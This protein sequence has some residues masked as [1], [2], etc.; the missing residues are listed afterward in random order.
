VSIVLYGG[1]GDFSLDE[2]S[3]RDHLAF[4]KRNVTDLLRVRGHQLASQYFAQIPWVLRDAN[5]WFNDEFSVLHATVSVDQYERVRSVSQSPEHQLAFRHIAETISE[6]GPYV[7]FIAVALDPNRKAAPPDERSL[8]DREIHKLVYKYIGVSGGYLGDFTYRSHHDFYADLELD[9]D[10]NKLPG[11]T[12]E[13]FIQIL[14][15]AP[16]DAQAKIVQG[17]L[18]R[19]PVDSSPIRSGAL[20]NEIVGWIRRLNTG[21]VVT[22]NTLRCT[23]AVVERALGDAEMLLAKTGATSGVDRAHT[24]LHGYLIQVCAEENLIVG[25]DANLTQIF[26]TVRSLHPKFKSLGTR[27]EDV[28]K[29]LGAMATVVDVLNPLRN[30]ASVAHPNQNL[31]EEPEALL[32]IN[33]VKTLLN[34]FDSKLNQS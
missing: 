17:I 9:I 33:S 1:G 22:L 19:F 11:T 13:R 21:A 28:G 34:Y 4:V 27:G 26:K 30:K 15:S 7:R 31:L 32:V 23:S 6:V 3:S 25:Q 12:K 16:L 10:P 14:S 29:L 24:A 18:D 2:A 20:H 5:N 8:K